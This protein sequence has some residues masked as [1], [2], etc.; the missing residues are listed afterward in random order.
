MQHEESQ[1]KVRKC[2]KR[3]MID[4]P[5][6]M[7]TQIKMRATMR[8]TSIRHYVLVAIWRRLQE[9]QKYD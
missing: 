1:E 5:E 3:L 2:P 6:D 4:V 7:H 9:E 8:N